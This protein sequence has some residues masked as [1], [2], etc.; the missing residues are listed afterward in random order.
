MKD[1]VLSDG[2]VIPAGTSIGV[3]AYGISIDG[4]FVENPEQFDPWRWS[5]KREE[6]G[7]ENQYSF[8][9]T[10]PTNLIFGLVCSF[11]PLPF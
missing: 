4:D 6:P 8:V 2:T 7:M 5:K 9:Q 1:Y 3:N 11:F 10:S